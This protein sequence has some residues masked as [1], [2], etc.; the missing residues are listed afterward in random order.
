MQVSVLRNLELRAYSIS[1][2]KSRGLGWKVDHENLSKDDT[3]SQ[4]TIFKVEINIDSLA[5]VISM[6]TQ[7]VNPFHEGWE[8]DEKQ[9]RADQF[10]WWV[11]WCND[12]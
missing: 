5:S 7:S 1:G 10:E 8:P 11:D 3:R 9:G 4:D 2:I 6:G 12:N